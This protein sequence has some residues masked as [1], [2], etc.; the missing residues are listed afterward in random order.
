MGPHAMNPDASKFVGRVQALMRGMNQF[1][2]DVYDV[3]GG[4]EMLQNI[5]DYG[6][7]DFERIQ[8]VFQNISDSLTTFIRT[9]GNVSH[10]DPATGQVQ[11]HATCLGIQWPWIALPAALAVLTIL[12]LCLVMGSA[13]RREIPVW[14]ASPL[15]W[16][17]NS[18]LEARGDTSSSSTSSQGLPKGG[19]SISVARME[20]ES[21]QIFATMSEG[22]TSRI[23]MVHVRD[24][25]L[26][27]NDS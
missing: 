21:K 6:R 23:G 1:G 7:V 19:T 4:P 15:P 10:S 16:I 14:K 9:H 27:P 25:N 2:D 17:L 11:L 26:Q 3:F 18:D 12:F 13:R 5:Y 24:H 8:D 22:G 20:D